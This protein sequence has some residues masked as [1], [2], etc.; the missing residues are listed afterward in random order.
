MD[1]GK[2]ATGHHLCS[3]IRKAAIV[4]VKYQTGKHRSRPLDI[5]PHLDN[6]APGRAGM[7]RPEREQNGL[8]DRW[9]Q[10]G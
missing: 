6:D 1:H 5:A 9:H 7:A 8:P 2:L 4:T 3:D 10:K